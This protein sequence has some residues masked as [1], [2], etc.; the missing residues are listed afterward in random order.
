MP[1]HD[2]LAWYRATTLAERLAAGTPSNTTEP[3]AE[4]DLARY[5]MQSWTSQSPFDDGTY[6]AQRLALD[7]LNE[8]QLRQLLVEPIE[9]VRERFPAC[10]AWLSDLVAAL[11]QPCQTDYRPFLSDNLKSKPTIGFL[12]AAAPFIEQALAR[13][14]TGI[15]ALTA[16]AA[17][18]PFDPNTIKKILFANLPDHLL[19]MLNRTMALELNIARLSGELEGVTLQERFQS[20]ITRLD[21]PE[22]R[23]AFLQQY[24]VLARLLVEQSQRWVSVS[25]EFLTRLCRDWDEI[26]TAFAYESNGDAPGVLVSLKGGIADTHRGG[27]SVFIAKFSSGLRLVYKPKSLGVDV[28]FQQLL[29]WLNACGAEMPFPTLTVLNR[30]TYGWVEFVKAREC[31]TVR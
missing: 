17:P 9:A 11:S 27:H 26:R 10:P 29:Q 25:L 12:T 2:H 23:R 30:E 6:F 21:Q 31:E 14:D 4:D 3:A 19:A 28:H 7:G 20:F 15:A 18:L 1:P 8:P 24:P 13:F 5:R 16:S 22:H